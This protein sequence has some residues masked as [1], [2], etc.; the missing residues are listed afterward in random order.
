MERMD[1]TTQ[2]GSTY[3]QNTFCSTLR[4]ELSFL[5]LAVD[6]GEEQ[7]KGKIDKKARD[8]PLNFTAVPTWQLQIDVNQIW[9]VR[10]V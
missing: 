6:V 7:K 1:K 9:Y 3:H 8:L 10:S 5:W 4:V 2:K